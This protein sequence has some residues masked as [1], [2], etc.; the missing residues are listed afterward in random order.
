MTT[1]EATSD[2]PSGSASR[3]LHILALVLMHGPV[4]PARL[5]ELS[6][7]SR[8]AVHRA[9]HALI[10]QGFVRYQLGKT[11]VIGTAPLHESVQSAFFSPAGVDA[12]SSAVDRAIRNKKVHCDIAAMTPDGEYRIVE[13]TTTDMDMPEDYFQSDLLSVLLSHF[14]PVEVAR[15]TA[16]QLRESQEDAKV[17]ADFLDRYRLAQYQGYLWNA[18]LGT[19]VMRLEHEGEVSIAIRLLSKRR[20]RLPLRECVA[21]CDDIYEDLPGMF[22]KIS[23]LAI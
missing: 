9:I 22:P 4:S 15:I 3:A 12:V 20:G 1:P 6:G 5:T 2:K 16:R 14:T 10:E 23:S 21:V 8:T 11:N 7:L 13:S 18:P 17:E 19:L